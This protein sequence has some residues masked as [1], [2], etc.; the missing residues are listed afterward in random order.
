M[1][2]L[3]GA[4]F[5]IS[6]YRSKT[7]LY[8]LTK[9]VTESVIHEH[10]FTLK[11]PY[12]VFYNLEKR[13]E[14]LTLAKSDLVYN[15]DNEIVQKGSSTCTSKMLTNESEEPELVIIDFGKAK[16]FIVL[17]KRK[18][19]LTLA[20]PDLFIK[21]KMRYLVQIRLCV[22]NYVFNT[23][24]PITEE[25]K[26]KLIHMI[27]GI[28]TLHDLD[29]RIKKRKRPLTLAK[30]DLFTYKDENEMIKLN[31]VKQDTIFYLILLKLP[32]VQNEQYEVE[33]IILSCYIMEHLRLSRTIIICPPKRLENSKPFVKHAS[34]GSIFQKCSHFLAKTNEEERVIIFAL[35]RSKEA[36]TSNNI[37]PRL[38]PSKRSLAD[39]HQDHQLIK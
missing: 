12:T 2:G 18:E 38:I 24:F 27:K 4:V 21:T 30:S 22:K 25:Q 39:N 13:N 32:I 35:S 14:T 1:K 5:A 31:Q 23:R 3:K 28:K 7:Y 20:K 6:L 8:L 9:S 33:L 16:S 11:H 37:I 17:A 34:S 10:I 29:S 26:Y 36:D 19:P 15:D